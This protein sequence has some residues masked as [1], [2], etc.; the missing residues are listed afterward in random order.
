M[1]ATMRD[2]F[3]ES[4]GRM[5]ESNPDSVVVLAD[6]GVS[7]FREAGLF[8]YAGLEEAYSDRIINVGIR[9]QLM[10]GVAAGLAKESFRPLVHSYTPFLL[11]RPY[12]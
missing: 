1:P 4:T 7:Q 5:L 10:V 2:A 6:I 8:K 11:E 12:E 9:E 3:I